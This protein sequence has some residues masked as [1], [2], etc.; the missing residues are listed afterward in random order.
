[1]PARIAADGRRRA[2][3][4]VLDDEDV[5]AR[6]LGDVALRVEHQR[7][8]E[9][10]LDRHALREHRRHVLAADLALVHHRV[11]VRAREPGDHA[12]DALLEAFVAEV[13]AP[14]VAGDHRAHRRLERAEAER[15][16]AEIDERAQ[17]ARRHLV[18]AHD[19]DA[20]LPS[21]GRACTARPSC[22][23]RHE[24]SRRSM[25]SRRRKIVR[26]AIGA[27]VRADAFERADAVVHRVRE[28]VVGRAGPT[29]RA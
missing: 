27:L 7:L 6:A 3:D 4:A 14:L 29:G 25:C 10:A 9:A 17:V 22:R 26:P 13:R 5:L 11:A 21:A 18:R 8:V 16:V 23:S 12:L 24:S 28:Q 2:N 15:A 20:R 1:M 19:V